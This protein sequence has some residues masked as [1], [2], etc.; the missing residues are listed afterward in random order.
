MKA[1]D[2][3]DKIAYSM[4]SKFEE[5]N[6]RIENLSLTLHDKLD[7]VKKQISALK[8]TERSS[9][10]NLNETFNHEVNQQPSATLFLRKVLKAFTLIIVLILLL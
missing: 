6:E 7:L 10:E 4:L 5:Q 3:F 8:E 1:V 2:K 9:E